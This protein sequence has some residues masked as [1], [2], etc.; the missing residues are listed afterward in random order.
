VTAARV[1]INR[2]ATQLQPTG[3]VW[4]IA[5]GTGIWT[6]ALA[7]WAST[8][9]AIDAAPE[10]ITVSS[11]A[12]PTLDWCETKPNAVARPGHVVNTVSR[13]RAVDADLTEAAVEVAHDCPRFIPGGGSR[14]GWIEQDGCVG[15]EQAA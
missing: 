9:T 2:L 15:A 8:V 1:R 14:A 5:C 13:S 7:H 11:N 12:A 6:A 10:A 4:E 3:E